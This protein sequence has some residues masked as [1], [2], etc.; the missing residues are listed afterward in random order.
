[1]EEVD[2]ETLLMLS[3]CA[4]MEQLKACGLRTIKQQLL[5]RKFLSPVQNS[6]AAANS[7]PASGTVAST[8]KLTISAM[9]A[10]SEED[11]WLYLIK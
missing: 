9:K 3:S 7:T 8:S 11:R 1:M 6:T 4:I 2:G 10:M 5:L